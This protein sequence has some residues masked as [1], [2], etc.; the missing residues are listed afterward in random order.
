M[1]GKKEKKRMILLGYCY[2]DDRRF[3][4]SPSLVHRSRDWTEF[5]YEDDVEF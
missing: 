2:S 5:H 1:E 3:P 4:Y